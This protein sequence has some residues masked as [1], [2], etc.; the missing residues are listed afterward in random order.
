VRRF[1]GDDGRSRL[2]IDEE[3]LEQLLEARLASAGLLPA[4]EAPAVDIEAFVERHLGVDFDPYAPLPADTLGQTSF[5]P[6]RRPKVSINR[7]LTG[8]ALDGEDSPLGV[9][10]R[11]RITL[12]HEGTHVIL[13][14]CLFDLNPDQ[15]VLFPVDADDGADA[16]TL[17]RCLKRHVLFRGGGA[18]WREVQ[19]NMGMAI[20]LMPR[21]LFAAASREERRRLSLARADSGSAA[22][23]ALARRLAE[24]FEVSRQAAAIRLE[25]LGLLSRPGQVELL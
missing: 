1:R 24:R 10:G 13:H 2:W 20:L 11:W 15:A 9:R 21:S 16:P 25:T 23:D 19:A 14:R 8:A 4:L 6:G 3:E 12:A 18:D 22:A 5:V 7:D 17:Q